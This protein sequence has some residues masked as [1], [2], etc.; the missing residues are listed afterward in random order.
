MSGQL[1]SFAMFSARNFH[2]ENGLQ[3]YV[4]QNKANGSRYSSLSNWRKQKD[5]NGPNYK[6]LAN[7]QHYWDTAFVNQILGMK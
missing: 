1:T 5:L 4:G 6:V 3:S 7:S 2:S